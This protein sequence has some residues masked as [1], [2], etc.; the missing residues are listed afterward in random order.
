MYKDYQRPIWVNEFACPPYEGCTAPHQLN[1]MQE[2]L[3]WLEDSAYVYRYAWFDNRDNRPLPKGADS[4]H[5]PNSSKLTPLGEFYNQ[6]TP[7]KPNPPP[8]PPAPRPPQPPPT[9]PGPAPTPPGPCPGG[10]FTACEHLCPSS[11]APVHE[12]CVQQC[13]ARCSPKPAPPPPPHPPSPPAPPSPLPANCS[14]AGRLPLAKGKFCYEICNSKCYQ[15]ECE[16]HYTVLKDKQE[17]P[18]LFH[19]PPAPGEKAKCS[20]D[21]ACEKPT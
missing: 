6:F 2:T 9:P 12:D 19:P 1:M 4:L 7:A 5:V 11:P 15:G 13:E 3:P 14:I 18:C 16:R 10:N 8:V 21:T 17:I 20:P